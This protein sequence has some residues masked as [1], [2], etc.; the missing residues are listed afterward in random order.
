V[1]SRHQV[2][3]A[4]P[5]ASPQMP[6][7][8]SEQGV[9]RSLR[10]PRGRSDVYVFATRGGTP[11]IPP[12]IQQD[13]ESRYDYRGGRQLA[14]ETQPDNASRSSH[15]DYSEGR[16]GARIPVTEGI[17]DMPQSSVVSETSDNISMDAEG[18]GVEL[19]AA[20]TSVATSLQMKSVRLLDELHDS[21]IASALH[22]TMP[23]P[24][25]ATKT[26][27]RPGSVAGWFLDATH[28][29]AGR[30]SPAEAADGAL[31]RTSPTSAARKVANRP[32]WNESYTSIQEQR[33]PRYDALID[34]HCPAMTSPMRLKH[35]IGTREL[36]GEYL[37]IIRERFEH[38]RNLF[39]PEGNL[40]DHARPEVAPRSSDGGR[41]TRS[42]KS[43]SKAGSEDAVGEDLGRSGLA[44]PSGPQPRSMASLAC[45]PEWCNSALHCECLE[46]DAGG[47]GLDAGTD[48]NDDDDELVSRWL[49][50][51]EKVDKLWYKMQI[52]LSVRES[53]AEASLA[54]VTPHSLV[55][56]R[57][58][59]KE[60]LQYEAETKR[61]VSGC[62]SREALMDVIRCAHALGVND[63]RLGTLK[64]DLVKLDRL[65]TDLVRA[66]G[67]W[68][69]RFPHLC[70]DETKLPGGILSPGGAKRRGIFVWGGRDCIE[71]VQSD[72][73]ALSRGEVHVLE[74]ASS[75]EMPAELEVASSGD[76]GGAGAG[77][78]DWIADK[79][80]VGEMGNSAAGKLPTT[81]GVKPCPLVSSAMASQEWTI[82]D[83]LHNG[84]PPAWYRNR[85]ARAGIKALRRG[86]QCKIHGGKVHF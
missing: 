81:T 8:H 55:R 3:E 26:H 70:V 63:A 35:L 21:R 77:M 28:K 49:R 16:Q 46:M 1:P 53:V 67:V 4:A 31:G 27:S 56:L 82:N 19:A 44:S 43:S 23:P 73:D 13:N 11:G 41:P 69:R 76:V 33:I 20:P 29:M 40:G 74:A 59:H 22:A 72:S 61:I 66:I 7:P 84:P 50:L 12:D 48:C 18:L 79:N 25:K 37:L 65:S 58:H 24:P 60:L 83:V 38:H 34:D 15:Y 36:S 47:E 39:D 30:Q 17:T 54:S 85:T 62:V 45:S 51:R 75:P 86:G 64:A 32:E 14:P 80:A 2:E 42:F 57:R 9:R 78:S 68:S 52:P 5:E 71:R 10:D 6:R